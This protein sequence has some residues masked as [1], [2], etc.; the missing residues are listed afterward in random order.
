MQ[1]KQNQKSS[2]RSTAE[3]KPKAVR[4]IGHDYFYGREAE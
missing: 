3:R 1:Q 2:I 4:N